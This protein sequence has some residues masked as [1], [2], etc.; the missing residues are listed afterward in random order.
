M[1][2]NCTGVCQVTLDT[3]TNCCNINTIIPQNVEC[4]DNGTPA[5]M[6]DNRIRFTAQITN[7]NTSLATYSVTINGGTT[8]TPNTNVSYGTTQFILG[9]GTAGGGA[10]YTITVTDTT[11]PT[12]CS[13]TFQVTDPGGCINSLPCTTPNCGTATIQVDRN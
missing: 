11:N 8:V 9:V 3:P 10:T 1:S 12:T 7:T 13:Q 4:L 5:L 6:T 2:T